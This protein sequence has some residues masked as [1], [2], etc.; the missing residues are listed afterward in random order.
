[1][2]GFIRQYA[3]GVFEPEAVRILTDAFDDAWAKVQAS[4]TPFSSEEYVLA[5]RTIVAKH[6]IRAAKAGELDRQRL[7]EGALLYL[8]KQKLSR[9]PPNGLT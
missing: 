8:S 3:D 6:I 5:G 9:T 2:H 1:M 7:G 4:K